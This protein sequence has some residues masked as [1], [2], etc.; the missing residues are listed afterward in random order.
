MSTSPRPRPTTPRPHVTPRQ[1]AA[2]LALIAAVYRAALTGGPDDY[3]LAGP[4]DG[5]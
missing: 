1:A 4:G 3:A 2:A 5:A